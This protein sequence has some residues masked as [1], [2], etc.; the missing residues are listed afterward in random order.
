MNSAEQ[1]WRGKTDDEIA[2]AARQLSDYTDEA[3]RLI[4][5]ELQRR[6]MTEPPPT[7]RVGESTSP[8]VNRYRDAYRVGS[9][10]VGLGSSL[11]IIGLVLAAAILLASFNLRGGALGSGALYAG[12]F[13]AA[14]LGAL[15]W[16]S[17]V[18]V[19]AQGQI[20]RAALDTAVATSPF[21]THPERTDAMGLPRIVQ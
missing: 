5:S 2:E 3:E 21:L 12:A 8:F 14:V 4:R 18:V 16:V 17:G 6:G 20:L 11:K 10:L 15:F 7:P 13:F 1:T 9:A 19:A